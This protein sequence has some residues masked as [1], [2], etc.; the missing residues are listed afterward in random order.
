[1]LIDHLAALAGKCHFHKNTSTFFEER[2]ISRPGKAPE[3]MR[4]RRTGK[5]VEHA[6]PMGNTARAEKDRSFLVVR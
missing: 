5:Y 4:H 2:G 3:G 6:I 1:V